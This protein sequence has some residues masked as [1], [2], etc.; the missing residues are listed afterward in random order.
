MADRTRPATRTV[1]VQHDVLFRDLLHA[2]LRRGA[3]LDVIGAY[4][5]G[6]EL[7]RD[8]ESLRPDVAVLDLEPIGNNGVQLALR[9]QRLLPDLGVV[10]LVC[11]RDVTLLSSLSTE[12]PLDWLYVVNKTTHGLTALQ[13][14]IQIT[15]ARL[16]DL[17]GAETHRSRSERGTPRL[18]DLT[19][20]Q[21][22]V[23]RLVIQGLSN[24]AIARALGLKE[25]SIEN[26]LAAIYAKFHPGADRKEMHTRVW[27]ALSFAR[28]LAAEEP[29]A[30]P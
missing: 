1:V 7:L 13:R 15:H 17:S 8:A 9:L 12:E 2:A 5:D 18:P 29:A 14:A 4:A 30:P 3:G 26:Q 20:R 21:R 25:K 24:R 19:E 22:E 28:A 6:S 16:H 11:Q 23:M 27:A 10:L